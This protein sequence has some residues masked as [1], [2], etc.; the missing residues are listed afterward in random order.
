MPRIQEEDN[1]PPTNQN[2]WEYYE[3]KI[4]LLVIILVNVIFMLQEL[5]QMKY[6]GYKYLTFWNAFDLLQIGF[7]L[8]YQ[9]YRMSD[10]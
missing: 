5:V 9:I 6:N 10:P 7:N 4:G 1:T 8:P 2:T 3:E